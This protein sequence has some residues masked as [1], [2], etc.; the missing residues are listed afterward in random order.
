MRTWEQELCG[1]IIQE[2]FWSSLSVPAVQVEAGWGM[3]LVRRSP[4]RPAGCLLRCS[5]PH[6]S[7]RPNLAPTVAVSA[8]QTKRPIAVQE[9]LEEHRVR[10]GLSHPEQIS[11]EGLL[12]KRRQKGRRSFVLRI[13]WHP[14]KDESGKQRLLSWF[15]RPRTHRSP[16]IDLCNPTCAD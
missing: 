9:P 15:L 12:M 7:D 16:Y 2:R 13:P 8:S 10:V 11:G 6:F 3:S 5:R 4:V 1:R 14:A